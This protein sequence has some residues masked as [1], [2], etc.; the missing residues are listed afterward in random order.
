MCPPLFAAIGA[1]IASAASA[2]GSAVSG[3]GLG[4]AASLV[5][6]GLSAVG[7]IAQGQAAKAQSDAQAKGLEQQASYEQQAGEYQA[8]R[9]NDEVQG[10]MGTQVA[11]GGASGFDLTGSPSDAISSTASQ[12]QMDIDAIKTNALG[13]A[14]NLRYQAN[15]TR[16]AGRSAQTAG[17]IGAFTNLA[18][19]IGGA[20]SDYQRVNLMKR[21]YQV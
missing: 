11:Q 6:T 8:A 3:I 9:K 12:G 7:S 17:Y 20:Y 5:G 18:S 16:A 13:Q 4:T 15:V 10:V 14:Q 21:G 1:G 19:G 2:V